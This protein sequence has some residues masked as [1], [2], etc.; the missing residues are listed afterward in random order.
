MITVLRFVFKF[1]FPPCLLLVLLLRTLSSQETGII[2]YSFYIYL[3][4]AYKILLSSMVGYFT[5]FLAITMLFKPKGRTKH[6]IQGLI[7]SNQEQIA[8]KLG[9][10]IA[11][12]FFDPK[13]L[14]AYIVDNH[15]IAD[16]ITSLNGY[17]EKNL[18]DPKTQRLITNWILRKF[19]MNSPRIYFA[20]LQLSEINMV[21]YLRE[22]VDLKSLI[23]EV[24]QLIEKNIEDGSIDLKDISKK[25]SALLEDHIP[26]ISGFIYD[27]MN[28]IIERQ[29]PIKKGMLKL[30]AWTFDFDQKAIEDILFDALSSDKFRAHA[31]TF[32][33]KAVQEFGDFLNSNQGSRKMNKTYHRLVIDINERFRDKGVSKVLT[34][35]NKY[36][37]RES[38]WKKME[39]MLKRLLTF[40]QQSLE[41]FVSSDRFDT[42]L[43]RSM[44][45]VLEKIRI[46]RIVTDKV[47]AYD[48]DELEKMVK[49]ASGEH[50]SAIEVLGGILGG[51]VGIALFDPLL[52]LIILIPIVGVG[53]LEYYLTKRWNRNKK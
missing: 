36:L 25:L 30:A 28:K 19:Q 44:P 48:T 42:F 39:G 17:I 11:D 45:A 40:A 41:E 51:F 8:E 26:E 2:S 33:E 16:S 7:P 49:D 24:T 29:S 34:E 50:L 6:G 9:E 20:L 46:S 13:D 37:E 4:V 15:I 27:Q 38:S 22:K 1:L 21:N 43:T 32:L 53:C 18:E 47:K 35:I 23:R 5:N 52:F 14:K 31:Y 10:G 3:D 12:N